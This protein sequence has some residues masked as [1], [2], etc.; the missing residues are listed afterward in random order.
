LAPFKLV[1]N[2]CG[3]LTEGPERNSIVKVY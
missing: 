2:H 3:L 1:K